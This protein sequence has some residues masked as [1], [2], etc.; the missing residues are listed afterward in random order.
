MYTMTLKFFTIK[1][2]MKLV[3]YCSQKILKFKVIAY[4]SYILLFL[5]FCCV[6]TSIRLLVYNLSEVSNI[7]NIKYKKYFNFYIFCL[8]QKVIFLQFIQMSTTYIFGVICFQRYKIY[9]VQANP[10]LTCN[11][12]TINSVIKLKSILYVNINDF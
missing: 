2:C 7:L 9:S 10:K 5:I 4:V 1:C 11:N 3:V 6:I 8:M 12:S